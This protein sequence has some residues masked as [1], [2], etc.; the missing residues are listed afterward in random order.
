MTRTR[1]ATPV[2][3]FVVIG[4]SVA[5]EQDRQPAVTPSS[6]LCG[7]AAQRLPQRPVIAAFAGTIIITAGGQCHQPAGPPLTHGKLASCVIGGG[8][9]H[10]ELHQ[11]FEFTSLRIRMSSACSATIF[12]SSLFSRSSSF[13]RLSWL[14]SSP[15]YSSTG[16]KWAPR[17]RDRA[18]SRPP[19]CL[20]RLRAKCTGFLLRYIA[21]SCGSGSGLSLQNSLSIRFS[22]RGSGHLHHLAPSLHLFQGV[23]FLF[24]AVTLPFH[25]L[26]SFHGCDR[27][28]RL[29]SDLSCPAFPAQD[30]TRSCRRASCFWKDRENIAYGRPDASETE[31]HETAPTVQRG[32]IVQKLPEG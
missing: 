27:F 32:R 1:K 21:S 28:S 23:Y 8:L 5:P 24:L 4:V 14:G 11:F 25:G 16:S 29:I 30:Q 13:S 2:D 12:L 9:S 20:L 31:I 15:P 18:G 3:A 7:V 6:A 10:L 19:A 26:Q 17:C 22:F